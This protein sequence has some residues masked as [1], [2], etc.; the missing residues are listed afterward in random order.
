MPLPLCGEGRGAAWPGLAP[1]APK[2]QRYSPSVNHVCSSFF[3]Y[4]NTQ[5][6]RIW[7]RVKAVQERPRRVMAIKDAP[8]RREHTLEGLDFLLYCQRQ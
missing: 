7:D 8:F 5:P 3:Y 4:P 1:G 6:K 2:P